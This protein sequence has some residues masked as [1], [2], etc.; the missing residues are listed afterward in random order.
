MPMVHEVFYCVLNMSL[1]ASVTGCAVLLVRCI[2]GIPR[3]ISV[4]L[5]FVPFWRD[6]SLRVSA[7]SAWLMTAVMYIG[8]LILLNGHLY[9]YGKGWFFRSLPGDRPCA[10]GYLHRVPFRPAD[11]ADFLG[12]LPKKTC[13]R[14]THCL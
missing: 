12:D 6:G 11:L 4:L 14:V 7:L 1:L 2:R 8:E 13:K 5:W 10:G 3:R 9:I